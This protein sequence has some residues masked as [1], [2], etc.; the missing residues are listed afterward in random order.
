M[1][2]NYFLL[3]A[4]FSRNCQENTYFPE[5]SRNVPETFDRAGT[6]AKY[7]FIKKDLERSLVFESLLSRSPWHL[8]VASNHI[9]HLHWHPM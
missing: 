5:Y 1:V 9:V 8:Q 3:L 4:I 6:P 7:T 2:A